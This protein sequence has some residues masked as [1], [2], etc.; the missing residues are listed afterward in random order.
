MGMSATK[1]SRQLV[2]CESPFVV[3]EGQDIRFTRD[4]KNGPVRIAKAKESTVTVITP[5]GSFSARATC[6]HFRGPSQEVLLEHLYNVRSGE[7]QM[8][9]KAKDFGNLTKLN[10]VTRTVSFD[11]PV[12]NIQRNTP[13]LWENRGLVKH[14]ESA[15]R[16]R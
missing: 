14:P 1:P 5:D 15:A 8:F 7:Q 4:G 2:L 9:S 10:F 13:R 3:L 11:G 6:V 16:D 12:E